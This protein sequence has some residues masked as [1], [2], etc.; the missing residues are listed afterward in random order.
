MAAHALVYCITMYIMHVCN[1]FT[2]QIKGIH[3]YNISNQ[4]IIGVKRSGQKLKQALRCEIKWVAK[5]SSF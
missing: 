1:I 4:N 2:P 5:V 3:Q